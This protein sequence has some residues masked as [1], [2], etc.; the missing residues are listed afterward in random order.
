MSRTRA[1]LT[2]T[3]ALLLGFESL[4]TFALPRSSHLVANLAAAAGLYGVARWAGATD[5]ELGLTRWRQGLRLGLLAVAVVGAGIVLGAV[6]PVTRDLFERAPGPDGA[7]AA[8]YAVV[9]AI[10]L[11]TV[12]LEELAFRGSLLALVRREASG[13][14]AALTSSLLF[15]AWHVIPSVWSSTSETEAAVSSPLPLVLVAT[16]L[17]GLAFCWLRLRSG[18]LLAPF[19]AHVATNSFATLS[20]W[21]VGD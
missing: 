4:R 7:A 19:L 13:M 10:P 5:P 3:I 8:L 18:S 6:L 12:A 11:G 15:A 21:L 9:I 17:A 14:T 16:F 20:V 1:G 2:L